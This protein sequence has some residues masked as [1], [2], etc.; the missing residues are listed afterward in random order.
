MGREVKSLCF[1]APT[2]T[3]ALVKIKPHIL[4]DLVVLAFFVYTVWEAGAWKLQ[5][6]L[7]PW[8]IGIPMIILALIHLAME[9]R[10]VVKRDSS[11]SPPVDFQFAKGIEPRLARW[12]TVSCLSWILGLFASVWLIGFSISIA[13]V[14]FLYLKFQAKERLLLS[15]VL[16]SACWLIYWVLFEQILYL[17]FPQGKIFFWMGL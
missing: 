2:Y 11:G 16:T 10:G 14:V 17:P 3:E 15:A 8:V 5:A 6:R 4:F 9:L 7:Y 13:V 1:A 12:R